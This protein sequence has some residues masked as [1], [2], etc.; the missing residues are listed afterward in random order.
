[1]HDFKHA[2][3]TPSGQIRAQPCARIWEVGNRPGLLPLSHQDQALSRV[4]L[5]ASSGLQLFR[6]H[7]FRNGWIGE[8]RP[9][10]TARGSFFAN[11]TL[12]P[13]WL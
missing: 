9:F 10:V 13:A 8:I 1:M 3:P 7:T 4:L 12:A 6:N 5:H 2:F 11:N